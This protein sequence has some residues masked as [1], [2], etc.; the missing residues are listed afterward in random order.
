MALSNAERQK[1]YRESRKEKVSELE[2][3]RN[4]ISVLQQEKRQLEIDIYNLNDR[5]KNLESIN[6]DYAFN[7]RLCRHHLRQLN[8]FPGLSELRDI[9]PNV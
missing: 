4:E 1:K 9:Y 3:L 7:F 5:C 6:S 8:E 2:A